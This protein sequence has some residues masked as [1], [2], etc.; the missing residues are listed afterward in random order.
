MK[1]PIE[2]PNA[3]L[4]FYRSRHELAVNHSTYSFNFESIRDTIHEFGLCEPDWTTFYSPSAISLKRRNGTM[5][6]VD[7]WGNIH[8]DVKLKGAHRYRSTLIKNKT[9]E[10]TISSLRKV[11]GDYLQTRVSH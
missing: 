10:E 8:M 3:M 6:R 4:Q 11:L 5:L 1:K 9:L 2:D 7:I